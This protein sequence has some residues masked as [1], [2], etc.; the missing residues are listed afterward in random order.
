V[1]AAAFLTACGGGDGGSWTDVLAIKQECR[2]LEEQGYTVQAEMLSDGKV[3]LE[4]YREAWDLY[5]ECL[6]DN[7]LVIQ[8]PWTSPLDGITIFHAVDYNALA[9][10]VGEQLG[11]E[12]YNRYWMPLGADYV[13]THPGSMEPAMLEAMADCM[14][15][16]GYEVTGDEQLLKDFGG[17]KPFEDGA[18]TERGAAAGQCVEAGM[19]RLH[20]EI[21]GYGWGY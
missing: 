2:Q 19:N 9:D 20:P 18:L 21:E 5:R 13:I 11:D 3:T 8:G 15:K 7:G 12:C 6:E 10:G 17:P 1:L 14:A 4:E 16:K